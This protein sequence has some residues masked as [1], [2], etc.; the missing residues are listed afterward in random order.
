MMNNDVEAE[1]S[2]AYLH[3]VASRAGV[4][5]SY[6][7]RS[8]DNSG[9]DATLIAMGDF[10]PGSLTDVTIHVQLKATVD[11]PRVTDG[12]VAYFLR[13]IDAYNRLR[14]ET[15][16]V[17]RV[18]VVL[19]LPKDPADWLTISQQELSLKRCAYWVS[20]LGGPESLNS[21]GQ[22]IYLPVD[23]ILSPEG[24]L[25]LITRIANLEVIRYEA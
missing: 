21:S 10:P 18:L 2:Y 11:E 19:F 16:T 24:L 23:Q 8:A 14:A 25:R 3:A 7:T 15:S 20:L 12:R 22:T 13:T 4:A 1:L 9:V 5:C 6:A 17:P